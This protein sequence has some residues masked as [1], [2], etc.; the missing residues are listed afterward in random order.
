MSLS[1]EQT[2]VQVKFAGEVAGDPALYFRLYREKFGKILDTDNARELSED[3]ARSPADR[4]RFGGAV[5]EVAGT[6]VWQLFLDT[7]AAG[8]ATGPTRVI[9]TGGGAGSGKTS[10]VTGLA[11]NAFDSAQIIYDTTLAD[12]PSAVEKV[13]AARAAGNVV[14]LIY[15][16]RPIELAARGVIERAVESGRCVPLRVV[17]D[18][19]F[20]AQRTMLQLARR[21]EGSRRVEI[22]VI[23]NGGDLTQARFVGLD[24]LVRRFYKKREAVRR[25]ALRAARAALRDLR[26]Q[27]QAIP[28]Y[29]YEAILEE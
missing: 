26:R 4:A 15:V 27:G 13:K 16:H 5:H 19:H 11:R 17:A 14:T 28:E 23:D 9:I 18:N 24:F 10:M 2:S 20:D 29:V 3:Y 1:P 21:Y 22:Q 12:L 6:L 8:R 25:R 7:L